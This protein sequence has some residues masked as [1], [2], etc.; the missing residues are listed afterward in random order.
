MPLSRTF[1]AA[2][3]ILIVCLGCTP[4]PTNEPVV[5]LSD[6]LSYGIEVDGVLRGPNEAHI[7][8]FVAT[9]GD[10]VTVTL[11][12]NGISPALDVSFGVQSLASD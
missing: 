9:A 10:Q 7:W 3:L 12:T 4:A 5:T 11:Q 2:L 8:A 6:L 1:S